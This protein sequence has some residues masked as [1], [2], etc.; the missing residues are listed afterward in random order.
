MVI[1]S[2]KFGLSQ[3]GV[4]LRRGVVRTEGLKLRGPPAPGWSPPSEHEQD[5]CHAGEWSPFSESRPFVLAG[6]GPFCFAQARQAE[7]KKNSEREQQVMETIGSAWMWAAASC[8][9]KAG[10]GKQSPHPLV[11]GPFAADRSVR[12]RTLVWPVRGR[13]QR[14]A[15]AGVTRPPFA[16][17][18]LA[19]RIAARH[20]R[21]DPLARQS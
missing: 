2:S 8:N 16:A 4:A 5:L 14:C 10:S 21:P 7:R 17:T 15:T 3:G 6:Q 18:T 13:R 19:A 9:R 12:R 1:K 11:P 20:L